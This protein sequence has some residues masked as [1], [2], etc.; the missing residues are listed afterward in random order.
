MR[1][2]ESSRRIE[3]FPQNVI[4]DHFSDG[5]KEIVA[6]DLPGMEV[7]AGQLGFVVEHLLQVV[8]AM[9]KPLQMGLLLTARPVP[10]SAFVTCSPSRKSSL[11]GQGA[12]SLLYQLG[13]TRD[14]HFLKHGM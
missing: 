6:G 12:Q 4:E 3:H 5:S 14:A 9:D 8:Y 2:I 1:R 11:A 13:I 10:G 7:N